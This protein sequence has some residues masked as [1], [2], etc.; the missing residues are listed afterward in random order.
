MK[1]FQ[2]KKGFTAAPTTGLPHMTVTRS[3]STTR[4]Y[5]PWFDLS[6]LA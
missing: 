5:A 1:P 3:E 4:P 6:T 2:A